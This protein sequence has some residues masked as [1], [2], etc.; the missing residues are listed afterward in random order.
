MS[1]VYEEV[2]RQVNTF[3][4]ART[5][6]PK[7]VKV[8]DELD[9]LVWSGR[10]HLD[11]WSE[12]YRAFNSDDRELFALAGRFFVMS[13]VAHL[14]TAALHAA[15]L[16]EAHADSVNVL[17]LLRLVENSSPR[18]REQKHDTKLVVR[19]CRER[20]VALASDIDAVKEQRDLHLAHVDRSRFNSGMDHFAVEATT[21]RRI[22]D[23]VEEVLRMVD[24]LIRG[25]RKERVSGEDPL[26]DVMGPRGLYDLFYFARIAARDAAVPDPSIYSK[27]VRDSERA[28][29]EV[30]RDVEEASE[31]TEP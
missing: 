30:E 19:N 10:A 23:G 17:Y 2:E 4:E 22:F 25:T 14:H 21:L 1:N 26:E 6:R 13:A 5:R 31:K 27:R 7:L 29:R 9:S 15:K 18:T 3:L 28:L 12:I 24:A 16:T 8:I 20:L 11:A